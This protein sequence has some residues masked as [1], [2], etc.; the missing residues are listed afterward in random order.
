MWSSSWW[1]LVLAADPLLAHAD[2]VDPDIG[3][4][5][6][7]V[8]LQHA[9]RHEIERRRLAV[10]EAALLFGKLVALDPH[11]TQCRGRVAALHQLEAEPLHGDDLNL[12]SRSEF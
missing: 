12:R 10:A 3:E 11:L 2:V 9:D 7:R 6:G 4:D 8:V 1:A 5:R